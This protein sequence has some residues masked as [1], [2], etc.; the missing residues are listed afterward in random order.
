MYDAEI[1]A[2]LNKVTKFMGKA[3]IKGAPP[4][5]N[6][7]KPFIKD[8]L[9]QVVSQLAGAL[10]QAGFQNQTGTLLATNFLH[11]T[12]MDLYGPC[13]AAAVLSARR[14]WGAMDNAWNLH[15]LS[16]AWSVGRN[17]LGTVKT[18]AETPADR[19]WRIIQDMVRAHVDFGSS[20][21]SRIMADRALLQN[22]FN[23]VGGLAEV[24]VT[25]SD[26]HHTGHRV[27]LLRF[28]CGGRVVYKPSD[29]TFQLLLMGDPQ[30]YQFCHA[31]YPALMPYTD[32]LFTTLDADLPA[33]RIV[34]FPHAQGEYGYM[35][36]VAKTGQIALANQPTYFRKLGRLITV[37]AVFGIT[38][39]HH[40]NVMATAQGPHLIDAEMGFNYPAGPLDNP[41]SHAALSQVLHIAPPHHSMVGG[42]FTSE[43]YRG[44]WE[45][46]T[47]SAPYNT[48]EVNA[49]FS[50]AL[51]GPWVQAATYPNDILAGIREEVD[52]ITT[53]VNTGR[54]DAWLNQF[55]NVAPMAR[56]LLSTTVMCN[57]HAVGMSQNMNGTLG[58]EAHAIGQ[59]MFEWL[60]WYGGHHNAVPA[61]L[62]EPHNRQHFFTPLRTQGVTYLAATQQDTRVA[63]L[64]EVRNTVNRLRGA[65][66]RPQL[67]TRLRTALEATLKC[68]P[69]L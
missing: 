53:A 1:T 16:F 12:A 23:I 10:K 41:I 21:V 34:A 8:A 33:I 4:H 54:V 35:Q 26:P 3:V 55:Q 20:L 44:Q 39:L 32:S 5:V 62:F 45:A 6:A 28:S 22:A 68:G 17:A 18:L 49:G 42:I 59:G 65:M 29:L 64:T 27:A 67:K 47:V 9:T 40:E 61:A 46:S 66:G 69:L 19:V 13:S 36:M 30:S 57:T 7:V 25:G 38:D 52:R 37:S 48:K 15:P 50:T 58:T 24:N 2:A 51:G 43:L 31:H 63:N 14:E 56:V 60:M 11:R